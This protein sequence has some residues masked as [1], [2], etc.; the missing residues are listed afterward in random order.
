MRVRFAPSPTGFLHIGNAR[1]ALINFIM[2]A[3]NG[4]EYLLRI[5]DTDRERSTK[6]SEISI[7]R[8]LKWLGI[9]WVEGPDI[10]GPC[11][12]YRQSERYDIYNEYAKRLIDEGKAYYCYCSADELEESRKKAEEEKRG[13]VYSGKCRNLNE[14]DRKALEAAGHKPVIRFRVPDGETIT[15]RD[16]LKGDVQFS[17][18]NIGGDFIIVRSDGNPIFNFIVIIDDALMKI[19]HVIRGEDHLSNTP[20]QILVAKALGL[21]VPVYAHHSLILGP[22]RSKLS[23]RHG[24]T[25]V[26]VYREQGYLKEALVNYL[27]LLGW[28]AE[29]GQEVMTFEEL[30]RQFDLKDIGQS[31]PVF[32]FQKL[33]WMNSIYIR[34]MPLDEA[35][36]FFKPHL[37]SAGY[38]PAVYGDDAVTKAVSLL[39]P[40]CEVLSDIGA[41]AGIVLDEVCVPDEETSA[42]LSEPDSAALVKAASEVIEELNS[43]DFRE[44]LIPLI[45]ERSGFKGKKLF[46]PARAVLTGRLNGPDLDLVM[47]ALGYDKCRARIKYCA[48]RFAKS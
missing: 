21:P 25:S 4:A 39:R 42:H 28:A 38:D 40:Y 43:A 44:K 3:K 24:I 6:E 22:D 26:A 36:E 27:A 30:V 1:T 14:A 13:F 32:D 29:S 17:S 23:K 9:N 19:T 37:A 2:A 15:V 41:L 31:A 35:V 48:E 33:R 46:H 20:K 16:M 8:D 12:P 34:E 11:G 10:G 18:E 5:E 7:L 47:E 45:K